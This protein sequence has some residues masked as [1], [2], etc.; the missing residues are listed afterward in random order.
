MLSGL[1]S[2]NSKYVNLKVVKH[3]TPDVDH[4]F[5]I[6]REKAVEHLS[7]Q[8]DCFLEAMSL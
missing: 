2:T 4:A 6:I 8:S 5:G 3:S 7:K 1:F